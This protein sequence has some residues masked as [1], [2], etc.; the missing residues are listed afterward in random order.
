MEWLIYTVA[1]MSHLWFILSTIQVV[2]LYNHPQVLKGKARVRVGW[3]YVFSLAV[4]W[5]FWVWVLF[6]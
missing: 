3:D 4:V 5:G 1:I 2:A 6:E